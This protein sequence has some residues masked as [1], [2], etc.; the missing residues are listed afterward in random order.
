M[1]KAKRGR[2]RVTAA[3]KAIGS[4]RAASIVARWTAT[5]SSVSPR[6]PCAAA[7]AVAAAHGRIRKSEAI[8]RSLLT[9]SLPAGSGR[10]SQN[11]V[12]VS[13]GSAWMI[14]AAMNH[15]NAMPA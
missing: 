2:S 15:P 13:S 12:V 4:S 3:I 11:A 8:A 6:T 9:S 7:T 1:P 5:W 10:V 14:R